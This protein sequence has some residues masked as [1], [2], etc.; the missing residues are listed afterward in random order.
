[1][2]DGIDTS[3][4]RNQPNPLGT[5][6]N[7]YNIQNAAQGLRLQQQAEQIRQFELRNQQSNVLREMAGAM[8]NTQATPQQ[9]EDAILTRA[10]QGG[11]DPEVVHTYVN[12]LHDPAVRKDFGTFLLNER[13]QAAGPGALLQQQEVYPATGGTPRNVPAASVRVTGAPSA[14]TPGFHELA[15]GPAG[16]GGISNMVAVANDAPNQRA[17]L[18][19][20]NALSDE[21]VS[22]PSADFEKRLNALA[23]RLFP[24]KG[25]TLSTE[26]LAKSEE[27]GKI[28]EQL[29]GQQA[30]AA[31]STNAFLTNAY[32][33]NP[34]L[35]LSKIGRQ[36]I[37][38][39]LQGN[40]DSI[41]AKNN[42]WD[43]FAHG[44]VDGQ[45]HSPAEFG[46]WNRRFNADFNPRVF[47]Y[48]RM[49]G[50]ERK[51]F[52]STL[53]KTQQEKFFR[54]LQ[55]YQTKGWIDLTAQ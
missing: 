33:T 43:A 2:P 28:S 14:Q 38:H 15:T 19:N 20:L 46:S 8:Y 41:V 29:A 55:D 16:A 37:T 7:V 26:Q 36:G 3:V 52:R 9:V 47:Q 31:H 23:Q 5:L 6:S 11:F 49:T 12:R 27:Y 1:M 35:Y 48:A 10:R 42:A 53:P 30:V 51:S 32:N 17:L 21:A 44:E 45:Q 13:S 22:G 4:Y 18:E 54:Q 34:N 24:G 39:M 25:V 50:D 40:V